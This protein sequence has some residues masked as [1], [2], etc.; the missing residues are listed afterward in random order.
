MSFMI[1]CIGFMQCLLGLELASGP[2]PRWLWYW[3]VE[4]ALWCVYFPLWGLFW[5]G[6]RIMSSQQ[7]KQAISQSKTREDS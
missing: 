5:I 3:R 4:L 2:S 6:K 7:V 1:W